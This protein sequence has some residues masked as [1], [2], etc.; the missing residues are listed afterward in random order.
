MESPLTNA[1]FVPLGDHEGLMSAA[2][3]CVILSSLVP[4]GSI[5]YSSKLPSLELANA[6]RP[7]IGSEA[8]SDSGTFP[9]RIGDPNTKSI[10]RAIAKDRCLIRRIIFV[11]L[12]LALF[13]AI[14]A[15]W[16][17]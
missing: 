17:Q 15:R 13:R 11:D 6:T 14:K 16:E 12:D 9:T 2:G 7:F 4:S 1:I 3:L 8:A 10:V 5:K